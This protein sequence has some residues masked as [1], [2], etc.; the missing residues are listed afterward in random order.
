LLQLYAKKQFN[1]SAMNKFISPSDGAS[2]V[3]DGMTLMIGGFLGHG[4]PERISTK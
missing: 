1:P 3:K 2:F 4:T